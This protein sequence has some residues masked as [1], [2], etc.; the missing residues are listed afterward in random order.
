MS[1]D[2]I[3]NKDINEAL[4]FKIIKHSIILEVKISIDILNIRELNIVVE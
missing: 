4:D 2:I 3:K 1:N